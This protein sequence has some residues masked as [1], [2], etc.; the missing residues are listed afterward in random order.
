MG[1][2]GTLPLG[3]GVAG[4]VGD[5]LAPA[6]STVQPPLSGV[7]LDSH[8]GA[9]LQVVWQPVVQPVVLHDCAPLHVC[10]HLLPEHATELW[11]VPLEL[12]EQPPPGQSRL[13][14]VAFVA[15][16]EQPPPG[17][18]NEQFPPVHEN[19][20]C[21]P[22]P[23]QVFAQFA[24]VQAAP[25]THSV[26][27]VDE[28]AKAR[29]EARPTPRSTAA[30]EAWRE[31]VAKDMASD[32]G[33]FLS[34]P[35]EA[36]LEPRAPPMPCAPRGAAREIPGPA[37]CGVRRRRRGAR[38][39]A[40]VCA[41]SVSHPRLVTRDPP[42]GTPVAWRHGMNDTEREGAENAR[43]AVGASGHEDA[44]GPRG[45]EPILRERSIEAL[46]VPEVD[47]TEP[48]LAE[49]WPATPVAIAARA[50]HDDEHT[51]HEGTDGEEPLP[52]VHPRATVAGARFV[53]SRTRAY[54]RTLPFLAPASAEK[55]AARAHV[56]PEPDTI[57]LE[58]RRTPSG[59]PVPMPAEALAQ[60]LYVPESAP[61]PPMPEDDEHARARERRTLRAGVDYRVV[62]LLFFVASLAAVALARW[63]D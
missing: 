23:P 3:E 8:V 49:T 59:R 2:F 38:A 41:S 11:P 32:I 26:S 34:R 14:D 13:T 12:S 24:H 53:R 45:T 47:T 9:P 10:W 54:A 62:A 5:V 16:T 50:P 57:D 25:A 30:R 29:A 15:D 39:L 18:E 40:V 28:H 58:P 46:W 22:S 51:G 48:A 1:T 43:G 52:L 19:A 33:K 42:F 37:R 61:P 6:P 7:Q 56:A 20:H 55:S 27:T 44:N 60:S 21:F 31:I 63:L 4:V 35:R 17:H 36:A